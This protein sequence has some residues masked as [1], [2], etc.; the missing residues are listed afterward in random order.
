MDASNLILSTCALIYNILAEFA[1]DDCTTVV[2][3]HWSTNDEVSAWVNMDDTVVIQVFSWNGCLD[4]LFSDF[5][6]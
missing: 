5:V 2:S 6:S 4:N 1:I 3:Y